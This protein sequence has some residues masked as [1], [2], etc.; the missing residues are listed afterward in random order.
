MTGFKD[1]LFCCFPVNASIRDGNAVAQ[2]VQIE[3]DLLVAGMNIAFEHDAAD[4]LVAVM[5]L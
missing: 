4:R 2:V 3:G 1:D 5:N